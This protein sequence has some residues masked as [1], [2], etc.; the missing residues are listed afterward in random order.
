VTSRTTVDFWKCFEKLPQDI[1]NQA[2]ERFQ[3]WK[4]DAFNASLHFKL[5]FDNVWSVRVTQYYRALGR[6]KGELIVWFWIGS[7]ADY[8]QLLKRL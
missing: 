3:I 6:R 4:E 5:L 8:D 1:Q 2:R 7:H